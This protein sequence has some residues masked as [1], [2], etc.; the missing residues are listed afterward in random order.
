MQGLH[1]ARLAAK[2]LIDDLAGLRNAPCQC[3]A[4]RA[5]A[6]AGTPWREQPALLARLK[7]N[8]NPCGHRGARAARRSTLPLHCT[9]CNF[10]ARVQC[11]QLSVIHCNPQSCRNTR[12]HRWNNEMALTAYIYVGVCGSVCV[13]LGY[14]LN[15]SCDVIVT[16]FS[17]LKY[18][19]TVLGFFSKLLNTY[20]V[21]P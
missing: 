1:R 20:F 17:S 9:N 15:I 5:G 14:F 8:V 7:G 21:V 10:P 12:G 3:A 13:H 18:L 4:G 19:C 2:P 11:E 16:Y 6:A